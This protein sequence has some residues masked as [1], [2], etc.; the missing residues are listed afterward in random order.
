M[1]ETLPERAWE[2]KNEGETLRAV[3]ISLCHIFC[4]KGQTRSGKTEVV[5]LEGSRL[6]P[7]T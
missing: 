4:I 1:V 7:V 6:G 5:E 3:R 2:G